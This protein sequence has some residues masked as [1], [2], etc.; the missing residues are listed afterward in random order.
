MNYWVIRAG[1]SGKF[2]NDFIKHNI[3]AIGWRAIK[4]LKN[5]RTKADFVKLYKKAYPQNTKL[6]IAINVG[7]VWSFF[8]EI[9]KG[10]IVLTPNPLKRTVY[11]GKI[12]SD[13]KYN[14]KP[15]G[16][17]NYPHR[18]K[19]KWLKEVS[20]DLFS[21]EMKNS[22]GSLLSIFN[23]NKH[24]DEINNI[25]S[26]KTI[27]LSRKIK[28]PRKLHEEVT[29]GEPLDFEGLT[30]AP[31]DENGVIFLFGKLHERMG[32]RIRAIKKGFPDALGEVPIKNKLYQRTIE[33]EYKSSNFPSHHKK[34]DWDKC[35]I[36][37]CWEHD[38]KNCP[39]NIFV[40][41]LKKEIKNYMT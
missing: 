9:K 4:N 31:V 13:Y 39:K 27:E 32:I 15:L 21:Q 40:I 6:S 35:D 29:I 20:R 28:F 30:N 34:K 2:F 19:V 14:R 18:R 23:I 7:Q 25:L 5:V 37:V 17:M 33:F 12:S 8:K 41:E 16:E 3:V 38:W 10:D 26:G 36:I 1:E 11:I 24:A 22:L